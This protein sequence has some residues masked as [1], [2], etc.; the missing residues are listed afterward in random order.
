MPEHPFA[1]KKPR[2][3]LRGA[4]NLTHDKTYFVVF[5]F[6]LWVVECLCLGLVIAVLSEVVD[7]PAPAADDEVLVFVT[8]LDFVGCCA[9]VDLE[10]SVFACVFWVVWEKPVTAKVPTNNMLKNSFFITVFF[11]TTKWTRIWRAF[12]PLTAI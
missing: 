9:A 6:D 1:Y 7:L 5:C 10:W 12:C 8:V 2:K 3:D 4:R 11:I